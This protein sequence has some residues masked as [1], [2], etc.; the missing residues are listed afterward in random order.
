MILNV[1]VTLYQ[2]SAHLEAG[3]GFELSAV[4]SLTTQ[5]TLYQFVVFGL[6]KNTVSI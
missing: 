4:H 2:I 3:E 5:W 1:K 6:N